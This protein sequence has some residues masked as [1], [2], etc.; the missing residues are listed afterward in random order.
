MTTV[1]QLDY[2]TFSNSDELAGYSHIYRDDG[3]YEIIRKTKD[4]S[5][6][7]PTD[8]AIL[9]EQDPVALDK[10]IVTI[11]HSLITHTVETT[12]HSDISTEITNLQSAVAGLPTPFTI[13][14]H[15]LYSNN[16]TE[17]F[18]PDDRIFIP[19]CFS[20]Y[21]TTNICFCSRYFSDDDILIAIY[22]RSFVVI[23]FT[24][25]ITH[26]FR[27]GSMSYAQ[28]STAA[29][30]K[31]GS[32]YW[33]PHY[34]GT[35]STYCYNHTT[36]TVSL[37]NHGFGSIYT[38]NTTSLI[39][40]NNRIYLLPGYAAASYI[41]YI[42]EATNTWDR[43]D[44]SSATNRLYTKQFL[45]SN[46]KIFYTPSTDNYHILILDTSDNTWAEVA[47]GESTNYG[48]ESGTFVEG[49]NGAVYLAP[50]ISTNII[51]IVLA[52]NTLSLIAS[53]MAINYRCSYGI[54]ASNN[55]I[56]WGPD[57]ERYILVIDCSDD[58]VA[59]V[60]TGSVVTHKC[61]GV[62]QNNN[63]VYFT[64][65]Y[66][67]ELMYY[68]NINTH[69]VTELAVPKYFAYKDVCQRINSDHIVCYNATTSN[70]NCMDIN[71]SG[72]VCSYKEIGGANGSC[73]TD[74]TRIYSITNKLFYYDF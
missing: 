71:I 38:Q 45:A 14:D 17:F 18:I 13:K 19:D 26:I 66:S 12:V 74:S 53:G 25:E 46:G 37:V 43:I 51:K 32:F 36:N 1:K 52:T 20:I 48:W 9:I 28:T 6:Y 61:T 33:L 54:L 30:I 35:E 29:I 73:F 60:D 44:I 27:T 16:S 31:N 58:S 57:N 47:I 50:Y 68:I 34:N 63:T 39:Y 62:F 65:A 21:Q 70:N 41:Y 72:D 22:E 55:K 3:S 7:A 5:A 56:Y 59:L 42:T 49:N 15:S 23:D 64:P 2:P 10:H 24:N 69:N 40:S 11:P 8:S 4:G 67:S